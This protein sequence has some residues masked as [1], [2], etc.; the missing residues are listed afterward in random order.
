MVDVNKGDDEEMKI[1]SRRVG[2]ELKA[3]TREALLA[4]ELFSAMPPWE[5][6]KA[7]LSLMVT[8]G[9]SKT[10][11]EL[12]LGTFDISRAHFMA[13]ADRELYIEAPAEDWEPGDENKAAKLRRNMYRFRDA[14]SGWQKDWQDLLQE[15][16]YEVGRANCAPFY[17]KEKDARGAVHGDDFYVLGPKAAIDH[18]GKVLRSKYSVR[19]VTGLAGVTTAQ[20][21]PLS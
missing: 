21:Q 17:N 8:S 5:M 11:E 18:I 3:K 19:E 16:G 12:E 9:V 1:R 6:I 14:S 2:K 15:A 7:L 20:G 10:N 13:K 4:H